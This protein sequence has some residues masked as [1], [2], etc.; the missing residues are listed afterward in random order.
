M[1][2]PAVRTVGLVKEFE[3]GRRTIWQRLRREP[4]LLASTALLVPLGLWSFRSADRWVAVH[5]TIAQH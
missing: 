5:G 1:T 4:D 3:R 2:E